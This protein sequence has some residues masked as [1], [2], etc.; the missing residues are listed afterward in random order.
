MIL[1]I[2]V[3]YLY[4]YM[5]ILY[6]CNIHIIVHMYVCIYIWNTHGVSP[7]YILH[8]NFFSLLKILLLLYVLLSD[9]S[10]NSGLFISVGMT[11]LVFTDLMHWLLLSSSTLSMNSLIH[12]K[13]LLMLL[14]I[15]LNSY[16]ALH[17]AYEVNETQF[18]QNYWI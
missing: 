5:Y 7:K 15:I 4:T 14:M 1:S 3:L 18:H 10:F 6:I 17:I 8:R 9:Y 2:Y 16:P 13:K 12:F 11:I